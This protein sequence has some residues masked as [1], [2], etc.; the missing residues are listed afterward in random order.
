MMAEVRA[1]LTI[2]LLACLLFASAR[3]AESVETSMRA[4]IGKALPFVETR[5]KAW[6]EKRGCVSCHQVPSMLRSMEAGEARGFAQPRKFIDETT[7]WSTHWERWTNKGESAGKAQADAT[8]VDTMSALLLIK[9]AAGETE[10]GKRFRATLLS[11]QQPDGSW[12]PGG[13]LPLQARPAREQKEVTTLW[14]LLALRADASAAA[15]K[16]KARDF[17]AGA[18]PAVTSE[19]LALELALAASEGRETAEPLARLL[20]V[21][22]AAGGWAWKIGAAPDAYGTG[23]A[24]HALAQAGASREQPAVA[25]ALRFLLT[26]Q[27]PDGSWAVPS[28]R[29]KDG[30]KVRATSTD[31]GTAWAVIGLTDHLPSPSSR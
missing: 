31:W 21:Q 24:L 19:R 12:Q 27:K 1:P 29:A 18:S 9:P 14:V 3:G 20:A 10:W 7:E 23:L 28:T 17:L 8:N 25:R 11:L 30:G 4:A 15:A 22:D 16:R 2:S 5:G 13:Q 26:T 6:I